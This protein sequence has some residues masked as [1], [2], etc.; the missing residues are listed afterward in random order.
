MKAP[1]YS[2]R[3]RQILK[4]GMA[5][6][7][8]AAAAQVANAS[9]IPYPSTGTPNAVSYTFTATTTGDIWGYF[10]GTGASYTEDVGLMVN[11][12][13]PASFGLNDK[14][15]PV[16]GKFDFGSVNAGDSLT[17]VLHVYDTA[18]YVYSN[19]A[20]NAP[21]DSDGSLGHNHIYSTDYTAGSVPGLPSTIPSGT[22]VAFEDLRFPGSDF[23][24][25]DDTFV[26]TG[27]SIAPVP[28]PTSFI[29]G[30]L[31]LLPFGVQGL[32]RLRDSR[33]SA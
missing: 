18:G 6:L 22:Y 27:V 31:L 23:N 3:S 9:L 14:T 30:A 21:Y 16:G 33:K 25:F 29:A 19:P 15:T 7:G 4:T 12:V 20:L 26:F 11:G 17:F 10:A 8:L 13:A 28:E 1:R 2:V 24:Y 5:V 32:R